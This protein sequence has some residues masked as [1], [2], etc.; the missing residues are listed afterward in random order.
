MAKEHIGDRVIDELM[1]RRGLVK[2]LLRKE[3]KSVKPL[4]MEEVSKEEIMDTLSEDEINE[5]IGGR[6]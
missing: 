2:A 6:I 4:R 1:R 3:Y 5:V